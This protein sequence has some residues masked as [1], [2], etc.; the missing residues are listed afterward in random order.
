M[1]HCSLVHCFLEVVRDFV[2]Q[3]SD[4]SIV[5]TLEGDFVGVSEGAPVASCTEFIDELHRLELGEFGVA[6]IGL[7]DGGLTAGGLFFRFLAVSGSLVLAFFAPTLQ[8][9]FVAGATA[10]VGEWQSA[11]AL[12]ADF[13]FCP[14][15]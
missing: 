7:M 4:F 12:C 15:G 6:P 14:Y 1:F 8:T 9:V 5:V 10:E 13:G 3:Y 2:S 11:S